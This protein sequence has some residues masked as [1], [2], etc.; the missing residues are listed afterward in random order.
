MK[1]RKH[2]VEYLSPG[3]F[4]SETSSF[5]IDSWST[6]VAVA[7]ASTVTERYNAKPYGFRFSTTEY[8]LAVDDD[9]N[10]HFV[11]PKEIAK[12]GIY[13]VT[14]KIVRYDEYPENKENH[15]LRSNMFGNNWPFMVENNNSWKC[16]QPFEP[17]DSVVDLNGNIVVCGNDP[18]LQPY[19][20]QFAKERDEY[21]AQFTKV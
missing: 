18:T 4:F 6:V 19:R 3:T 17:N 9:G 14:G 21:Y 13:Y 15:I 7:M 1:T 12:S 5:P 2:F 20:K 16:V 11:Q 10:Q 8:T